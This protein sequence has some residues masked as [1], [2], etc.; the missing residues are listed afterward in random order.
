MLY[1]F[2]TEFLQSGSGKIQLVSIGIVREDGQTFYMESSEFNEADANDFVKREVLPRLGPR[3]KRK[4][5]AEIRQA[6]IEWVGSDIPT[7][8][9]YYA[10][11]DAV[12]LFELLGSFETQ[13]AGWPKIVWDLKQEILRLGNPD[14]PNQDK[15]GEHNAL[16]DAQWLR[17]AYWFLHG[18]FDFD[19][20]R[21]PKPEHHEALECYSK[22]CRTLGLEPVAG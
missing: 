6:L 15:K 5:R 17:D 1:W 14:L 11:Y 16:A 18:K 8:V 10:A 2:D 22:V 3:E 20:P 13:P 21:A 19:I 9:A 4:T 7:F 12:C